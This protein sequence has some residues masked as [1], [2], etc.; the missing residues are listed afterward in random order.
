MASL[1]AQGGASPPPERLRGMRPPTRIPPVSASDLGRS[2]H[3]DHCVGLQGGVYT[4]QFTEIFLEK[5]SLA[6]SEPYPSEGGWGK[7][8]LG[9][10]LSFIDK[11]NLL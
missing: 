1:F 3:R 6:I 7:N 4:L 10:I 5:T 8:R 2:R 11:I 9:S